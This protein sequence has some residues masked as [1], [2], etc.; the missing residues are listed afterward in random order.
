M[1]RKILDVFYVIDVA[2]LQQLADGRRWMMPV[3]HFTRRQA[4]EH[5]RGVKKCGV[6]GMTIVE[7]RLQLPKPRTKRKAKR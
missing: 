4:L 5:L 3:F 2:E 7:G 1:K 6:K